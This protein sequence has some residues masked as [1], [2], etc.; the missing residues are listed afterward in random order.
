MN[1]N[2]KAPTPKPAFAVKSFSLPAGLKVAQDQPIGMVWNLDPKWANNPR[3]FVPVVDG[4]KTSNYK[5]A[6]VD[7]DIALNTRYVEVYPTSFLQAS[8]KFCPVP[9]PMSWSGVPTSCAIVLG[10]A[11]GWRGLAAICP[12]KGSPA[13]V[14]TWLASRDLQF[15]VSLFEYDGA[16][17][18]FVVADDKYARGILLSQNSFTMNAQVQIFDPRE[19]YT[20]VSRPTELLDDNMFAVGLDANTAD[21]AGVYFCNPY[22]GAKARTLLNDATIVAGPVGIKGAYEDSNSAAFVVMQEGDVL[23]LHK[24]TILND[25]A[26]PP[27]AIPARPLPGCLKSAGQFACIIDEQNTVTIYR[28]QSGV[29]IKYKSWPTPLK[30][31][32]VGE[33]AV[34]LVNNG[35]YSRSQF[36]VTL[37]DDAAKTVTLFSVTPDLDSWEFVI[38]GATAY[39]GPVFGSWDGKEAATLAA[40]IVDIS[41]TPPAP[42]IQGLLVQAIPPSKPKP[43][44]GLK[45]M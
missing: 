38:N 34:L 28:N 39:A 33:P 14:R 30:G 32:V 4:V 6:V 21:L 31:R 36:I 1:I 35:D 23:N 10:N 2:I 24:S 7:I 41:S 45:P 25:F 15:G 42:G 17:A 16:Q 11:P 9:T 3:L 18:Q 26:S 5:I 44:P 40:P 29:V 20:I 8:L 22:T 12:S 27:V 19:D 37:V 43:K 13:P